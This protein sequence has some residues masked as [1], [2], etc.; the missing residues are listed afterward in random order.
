MY[1]YVSPPPLFTCATLTVSF[2]YT[3]PTNLR[4]NND[5]MAEQFYQKQTVMITG[6]TGGLGG[7]VLYKLAVVL[8]VP[9]IFALVRGGTEKTL[10]RWMTTMPEEFHSL[11]RSGSIELID[12]DM[13]KSQ[14]GI[15]DEDRK[16]LGAT[17]T[18]VIHAAA[19]ISLRD[20]LRK[21]VQ[22][23]CLPTLELAQMASTFPKLAHFVHISSAYAT[24]FMPDGLVKEQIYPIANAERILG[25]IMRGH[26][27]DWSGYAWPYAFSKHLTECL[28][29]S[30]FQYLPLLVVRPS[31]IG[32]AVSQPHELYGPAGSIPLNTFYSRLMQPVGGTAIFY[33]AEGHQSGKNILDEI[34]VDL[35]ANIILQH[36][37]LNTAGIIHAC[38]HSYI[39]KTLDRI[40][41]EGRREVPEDWKVK[42][43][44]V[45]FT[46]D[47]TVKQSPLAEFYRMAHR[48]WNFENNKSHSLSFAGP[49]S[50]DIRRHDIRAFTTMRVQKIFEETK[51]RLLTDQG[52]S[53]L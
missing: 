14:W 9:K 16:R 38:C 47:R 49:L 46:T 39:P 33:A 37:M 24:S 7:C 31:S 13:S 4:R 25:A 42:M 29:S 17:V 52:R 45:L 43:S 36:V 44:R 15:H 8:K 28:L 48:N 40:L 21:V 30:R 6:A 41:A 12:A 51:T 26:W 35:V 34:P 5:H 18:V 1:T 11:W 19:N 53:M 2:N 50:V 3:S 10:Q 27:Q 22:D 23:N 32:P 20:S